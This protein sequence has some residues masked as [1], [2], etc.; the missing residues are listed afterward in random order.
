MARTQEYR[1]L[2]PWRYASHLASFTARTSR[3][4]PAMDLALIL[5]GIWKAFMYTKYG[6]R[7][8]ANWLKNL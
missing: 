3:A 4:E 7:L 8:F 6:A 2:R 5:A 1:I